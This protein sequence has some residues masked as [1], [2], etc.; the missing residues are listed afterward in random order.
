MKQLIKKLVEATGPSGYEDNIRNMIVDEIKTVADDFKIDALGNLIVRKGQK[1]ADGM[2][3]MLAA[4]M[5]EIGIIVTH[6]DENGFLRFAGIGG[7]FPFHCIGSRVEFLNGQVGVIYQEDLGSREKVA[8]LQK[9]YIDIGAS[10]KEE[11]SVKIGDVAVFQRPFTD[12]GNR[13]VS[14]AMDDR[15]GVAIEIEVL[16]QLK[17]SPHEIY[18]VFTT[19]EEV[20]TRGATTAAFGIDPDLGIAIDI[21]PTGDVPKDRRSALKLAAGPGIKVKDT[22]M[23]SD[24]RV[25]RSLVNTAEA[26]NIPYQ[27]EILLMGS[28]DARAI[29]IAKS[30]VPVSCLSIP[31]RYAHSPSE[32]VD[33]ND[34]QNTVKLLTA[35]LCK[36]INLSL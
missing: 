35:Y 8:P 14:K 28:T 32:M 6:I 15:I 12:L 11:C 26:A 9:M 5:D 31:T 21:A 7:V 24:P 18:F 25:V 30:G 36:P 29:Q 1:S 22:G 19:Q 4:H 17:D 23:I 16:K 10:S 20:G 33:Y 13:L 2:R 3:I 34:V 27:M